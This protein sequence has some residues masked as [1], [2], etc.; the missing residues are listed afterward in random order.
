MVTS[1]YLVHMLCLYVPL[2]F[3]GIGFPFT[4]IIINLK[5]GIVPL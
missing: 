5:K 3:G 1:F 4:D 2:F